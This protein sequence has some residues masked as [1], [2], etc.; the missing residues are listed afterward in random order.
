M[1]YHAKSVT[2]GISCP[3][4]PLVGHVKVHYFIII[5]YLSLI[6]C[7][8]NCAICTSPALCKTCKKGYV[9]FNSFCVD[10]SS[11]PSTP[12]PSTPSPS[13]PSPSPSSSAVGSKNSKTKALQAISSTVTTIGSV[14]SVGNARFPLAT[15]VSGAVQSTRYLNLTVTGA[16]AEIYQ[17]WDTEMISWEVPNA[18]SQFDD[19]KTPPLIFAQ[20]GTVAPFLTNF[21][22]TLLTIV[23]GLGVLIG[24]SLL[25]FWFEKSK[26]EGRIPDL[27][28]KLF[29]GSFNFVIV[30]AYGCLD[31]IL[32]NAVIDM[33]TNPFNTVFACFSIIFAIIFLGLGCLLIFFNFWTVRKYQTA[34]N[35]ESIKERRRALEDFGERNKYWELFYSD[36]NDDDFWC[37][38]ALALFLIRSTLSNLIIAVFYEYP[39]MQTVYLIILD[40]VTLLFLYFKMPFPTLRGKLSQYYFETITLLVHICAFAIAM[41]DSSPRPS[42]SF[43]GFLSTSIIYLNITLVTGSISFMG[44]EI[45]KTIS[46]KTK[47]MEKERIRKLKKHNDITT[48]TI[49][50][51]VFD[52]SEIRRRQVASG[53]D[54][55]SSSRPLQEKEDM[56]LTGV[57]QESSRNYFIPTINRNDSILSEF[58]LSHLPSQPRVET[59]DSVVR[60]KIRIMRIY[61]QE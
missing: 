4:P 7:Q 39:L 56:S 34:K 44:I 51:D 49:T 17:T 41:E 18:L 40:G 8:L 16:L 31:G 53:E 54:P 26:Y 33:K 19:F 23:I 14:I 28:Q 38:S 45:Y 15:I 9:L 13:T 55:L 20:Y 27:T 3:K 35:I 37:Q 21:W 29:A 30:Q 58:E 59:K 47:E 10:P 52:H 36:F 60:P 11:L 43:I 50:E 12:S 57:N 2:M 42:E 32:F 5:I 6:E 22:P 1:I 48:Q 25:K 61:Q 24:S 46:E